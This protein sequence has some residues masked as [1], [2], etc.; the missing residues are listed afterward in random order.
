VDA[1]QSLGA[2][3]ELIGVA[4]LLF[5]A[6]QRRQ[7]TTAKTE[8]KLAVAERD[9]AVRQLSLRPPSA[10]PLVPVVLSWPPHVPFPPQSAVP[11]TRE[12]SAD[13]ATTDP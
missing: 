13:E 11:A 7:A 8:K 12:E 2:T 6:W 4:A 9:D 1:C 10:P 3:G 5:A